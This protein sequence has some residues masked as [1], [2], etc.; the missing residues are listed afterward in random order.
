MKMESVVRM[1]LELLQAFARCVPGRLGVF[2]RR[3]AY[4]PFMADG[5]MFEIESGVFIDRLSNLSLGNGVVIESNCS[6]YC[7]NSAMSIGSNCYLNKNVRLGSCGDA[8]LTLGN[9]VMVGPNVVMDTSNH[10]FARTDRSIKSQGLVFAPIVVEDDVWIGANVVVTS[11][12]T[13]GRG[14][15]VAAG[16]VV[17]RDVEPYSVVGGVPARLIRKRDVNR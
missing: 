13:I 4:R 14:S 1:P 17:T 11:G 9:E 6:L 3:N 12:A 2:L 7:C 16:A 5:R 15:V 8:P 10:V